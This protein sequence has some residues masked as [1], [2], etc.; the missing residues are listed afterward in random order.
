MTTTGTP[1]GAD[2]ETVLDDS[3]VA[4]AVASVR[5]ED[6]VA[7]LRAL[8]TVPSVTGSAAESEAQQRLEPL[9][10]AAGLETDLWR[11]DL[12]ETLADP[13]FPGLEAPRTEAWG[14]VGE[15]V[16]GTGGGDGPVVVL[17]GHIDVVPA[18]DRDD[19]SVD[20]WAG[21]VRGGRVFGRGATDMKAGLACQLAAVTALRDAGVRLR[22]RVALHSVVGEEDGGLGTFATLRRGHRGDLAIISEPTALGVVPANAGAL[23][24]RLTVSGRAAHASVRTTGVDAMDHY[25][26]VHSAL[27]RLEAVRNRR[28]DP[29][30]DRWTLPWPLS[31]GTVHAGDWASTVPDRVVAEGRLGVAIGEPVAAA[32]AELE[33]AVAE[34]GAGDPWLAA[35]P[36]RVEWVGGQFAPGS[37]PADGP[38]VGLVRGAHAALAGGLPDVHGVPYGSDLRLLVGAGVPTVQYGPGELA[39]A[40]APDESVPVDQMV[41][42]TR[43]LVLAVA[44]ACGT[45]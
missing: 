19:W 26:A 12:D 34:L 15:S 29:L 38:V 39:Q 9:L 41:T 30:M 2:P 4:A 36:V 20:P 22:G 40:H 21:V 3:R 24:F 27:R 1:T 11:I 6:L 18:G 45:R 37:T 43:T 7:S 23:T 8:L 5:P 13:D 31:V 44:T 33:A 28:G 25:L 10:R 35:H 32:R 14:L 17:N 42:V 16:V